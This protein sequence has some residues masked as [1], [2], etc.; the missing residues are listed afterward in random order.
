[1]VNEELTELTPEEAGAFVAQWVEHRKVGIEELAALLG[2][3][4]VQIPSLM[5][6]AKGRLAMDKWLGERRP[7]VSTW[8]SYIYPVGAALI[9]GVGVGC[10][11]VGFLL[12]S[13][14]MSAPALQVNL[15][16]PGIETS[17][18][19]APPT[20]NSGA[21]VSK[22]DGAV[23]PTAHSENEP[24]PNGG[25]SDI[26]G[27]VGET[28]AFLTVPPVG[29]AP[30]PDNQA[31][32]L[33]HQGVGL[34][35]DS[36]P[37]IDLSKIIQPAMPADLAIL[38]STPMA[39][40]YIR[41]QQKRSVPLAHKIQK[42]DLDGPILAAVHYVVDQ[43]LQTDSPS[44]YRGDVAI[45]YLRLRVGQAMVQIPIPWGTSSRDQILRTL[46]PLHSPLTGDLDQRLLKSIHEYGA[47]L[48][49][50]TQKLQRAA[51]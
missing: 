36:L 6:Q 39:H 35:T 5:R 44:P 11:I 4:D 50:T 38:V 46:E 33:P 34:Q 37:R 7:R 2:V 48:F 28:I 18:S 22:P 26:G 1:M 25:P 31:V 30:T 12:K 3:E 51:K 20:V 27:K 42:Q 49:T 24:I 9:L 47:E 14:P 40:Y 29:K 43:E 41:G 19:Q 17:V 8:R 45:A 13:P 21:P 15:P 16:P 32:K 23:S 10:F